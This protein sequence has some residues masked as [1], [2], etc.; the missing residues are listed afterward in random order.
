MHP[1]LH[2]LMISLLFFF[3]PLTAYPIEANPVACDCSTTEASDQEAR[4]GCPKKVKKKFCD[5][6]HQRDI[7][8]EQLRQ[9]RE[10]RRRLINRP[11]PRY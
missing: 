6:L 3:I 8:K 1:T 2:P 4:E 7:L 9:Q 5:L 11:V 10:D